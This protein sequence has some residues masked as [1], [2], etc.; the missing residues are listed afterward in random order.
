[1]IGCRFGSGWMTRM[2]ISFFLSGVV[3]AAE[4]ERPTRSGVVAVVAITKTAA[5]PQAQTPGLHGWPRA[6]RASI[7]RLEDQT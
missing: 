6:E 7:L 2:C 4:L 1:M 5:P 3:G